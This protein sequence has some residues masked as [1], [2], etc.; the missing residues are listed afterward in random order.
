MSLLGC[1]HPNNRLTNGTNPE[2]FTNST[3]RL[4]ERMSATRDWI[5]DQATERTENLGYAPGED[6]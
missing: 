4:T 1:I 5:G 6:V 3:G 2:C